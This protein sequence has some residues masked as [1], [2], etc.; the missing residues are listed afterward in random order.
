M[1][2]IIQYRPD[3][4]T[5]WNTFVSESKNGVFLFS[6]DYMEYHEDRFPDS[7]Y[8]FLHDNKWVAVLPGCRLNDEFTSHSGLT[9]GGMITQNKMTTALMLEIFE[10]L[11]H[12]LRSEN[13]KRCVYKA[14]PHFYHQR[15]ADE[16]LYALFL[17][18][19]SLI[20]RDVGSVVNPSLPLNLQKRRIRMVNKAKLNNITVEKSQDIEAYW[21]L[22]EQTLSTCHDTKPAHSLAEIKLLQSRFPEKINLWVANHDNTMIAG[23]LVYENINVAHTQYIASNETGK[24]LHALDFLFHQLITKTYNSKNWISFGVSTENEGTLLNKGLVEYKEGFGARACV[25]DFYELNF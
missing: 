8:I 17:N 1:I 21:K 14:I 24:K 9:F 18:G 5:Q 19:F 16:D 4:R 15:P 10:S 3:L 25:Q 2:E 11:L 6:R 13:I 7:S 23:T 20:R 12:R 22:L